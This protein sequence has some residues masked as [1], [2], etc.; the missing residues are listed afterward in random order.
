MNHPFFPPRLLLGAFFAFFS[1][2]LPLSASPPFRPEKLAQMDEAVDAAVNR[3]QLPGGVLWLEHRGTIYEKAYG[4]RSLDPIEPMSKETL[5]DAASL[6][7]VIATTPSIMLLY[8]RGRIDFDAPVS[9]Y[10]PEF[11]SAKQRPVTIRHL[12]TH[13]SGLRPGIAMPAV[14]S[15]YEKGISLALAEEPNA[16]PGSLLRYSDINFILLGEVVRRVSGQTL[17]Q[18]AAHEIYEPLGMRDTT[19]LPK[20]DSIAL[21]APTTKEAD[22]SYI[23]GVVHDPTSRRMG[24]V[25][26]HAG[27]FTTAADLAIYARMLLNQGNLNGVELFKKETV[28]L[29]TSVNTPPNLP[30]RGLGWDID[31]PY[32]GPRGK[33]FPVGSY[34]HTGW[35]GTSLWIDPFS[36][37]FVI[38][39]SNRN[40]PT[41]AGSVTALRSLLGTLA[42]EGIPDFNFLFVP[43]ALERAPET[44]KAAASIP[45]KP[46][47]NGIDLLVRE[48]F[49]RL[50]GMRLGLVTNH[51]G[52]DKDRNPTIDLFHG[53][54]GIQL[55]A[56]FSPE[57]G[58][59]GAFDEKINDSVDEKTGLPVYSLYGERRAPAPEQLHDL[60]ALVFDIQDV[61]SRFY[62]YIST[63][64]NC[65][66]AAAKAHIKI[67]ILDR[68]NPINGVSVEGPI[69]EGK[70]SFTAYHAI[71]VRHGMTVGE[72]AQLF[73]IERGF[74]SELT[75]VPVEG[76]SRDFFYDQTTLPWT[77]PSPN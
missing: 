69:A 10:L 7:K 3:H 35:T 38:F 61:G 29:M 22:G 77:N 14:S 73:N 41:E 44:R 18:F 13:T 25:A 66:E 74:N 72:L 46:V 65:L 30:R 24:G 43:G 5:F 11:N 63:M 8:Q 6:T 68:V 34:G 15:G 17:D 16:A 27:L 76:W 21:I 53:A 64:G 59:R 56:L 23:R 70:S 60:D 1:A 42:A 54:E 31:S 2:L 19:F 47:L 4:N 12:M 48:K 75:V 26:G 62:T 51:T 55:K 32:A 40:H 28:A 39:L 9:T 71:P 52:Q 67:F 20:A 36:E 58:I 45:S 49:A 50:Q 57:H 33:Y 37:T